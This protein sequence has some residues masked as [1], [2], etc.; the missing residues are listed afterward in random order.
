MIRDRLVPVELERGV[1]YAT[2]SLSLTEQRTPCIAVCM[3]DPKTKLCSDAATLPR[4]RAARMEK[5]ERLAVMKGLAARMGEAASCDA[6][7]HRAR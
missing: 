7:A 2:I 4:S 6:A 1:G 5:A 3:M